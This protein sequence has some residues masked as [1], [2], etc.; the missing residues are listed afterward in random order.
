MSF[1]LYVNITTRVTRNRFNNFVEEGTVLSNYA[2]VFDLLLR[3]RQAS[4][5]PYLVLHSRDNE[6]DKGDN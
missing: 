2:H 6:K 1:I 3:L 5:H 4:N